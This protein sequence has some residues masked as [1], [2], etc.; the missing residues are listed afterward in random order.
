MKNHENPESV[1]QT[2]ALVAGIERVL[3]GITGFAMGLSA[4]GILIAL[5]LVVYAVV[6]RYGFNAA[7][8]WVDD[9]VGFML[10]GIVMLATASTLRRGQH[11]SVDMLTGALSTRS[12]RAKRI[13]DLWSALAVG[14]FSVMLIVNGWET[15]MSSRMLGITTSGN[16]EIPIY[17]L[18]LLLPLGGGLMLL[19][20][21]EALLRLLT[22][23]PSLATGGHHHEENT[24]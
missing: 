15:A 11:V 12:P 21:I 10:A 2:P 8:T 9:T 16:V 19:V 5:G 23:T 13:A 20:T 6:A 4:I 7:P 14:V 24:Q 17:W 22:N 18:E 1:R 3:G